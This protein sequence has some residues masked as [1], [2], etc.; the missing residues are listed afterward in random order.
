MKYV[1]SDWHAYMNCIG[2]EH[3]TAIDSLLKFIASLIFGKVVDTARL[4]PFFNGLLSHFNNF[5]LK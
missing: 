2:R 5:L 1:G 3:K 4:Y